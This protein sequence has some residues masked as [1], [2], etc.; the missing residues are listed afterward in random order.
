MRV[1]PQRTVP[2]PYW[3]CPINVQ[4]LDHECVTRLVENDLYDL[5]RP[6]QA[7]A[8]EPGSTFQVH[9]ELG[10]F[11]YGNLHTVVERRIIGLTRFLRQ[12]RMSIDACP[13]IGAADVPV[14][15]SSLSGDSHEGGRRPV[16]IDGESG[17]WVL[18]FADPRPHQ[19]LADVLGELSLAIGTDLRPPAVI[20]DPDHRWYFM[21]YLETGTGTRDGVDAF[22]FALGALTAVA[23]CL[24]MVDLH[25]ENLLV[26]DGKPVIVDPECILYNFASEASGDR[27]LSTGLLSHNPGLS[28]L[29][30]GDVKEQQ[31]VHIGLCEGAD[32]ILDYRKP[33]TSF[34]N[35]FR[36]AD[37]QL[38]DPAAHRS[39]L[40]GGFT[41]AYD[42]F[43]TRA[44]LVSD[45]LDHRVA[46]DFR[47][48]YLVRKTRLY[49]TAIHMLNL[50]VSCRYDDWRDGVFTRFRQ[51]GYFPGT[52]TE[53]IICA[54]LADMEARDVP[55]FWVE[56]SEPVIRHHSGAKQKLPGRW[57]ASEQTIRDIRNLSKQDMLDQ[58]GVLN[59]FLDAD[60]SVPANDGRFG[61][62]SE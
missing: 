33:A 42:W 1:R 16:V 7:A 36:G 52:V 19:L 21:P 30:G 58:L 22:M 56:A 38:A 15:F 34:H 4:G 51:A 17:R 60:L 18:K 13:E 2:D 40:I 14:E 59:A 47:I 28:A 27:L 35:R 29:R 48:R 39:S 26:F 12:V 3:A 8:N 43:R 6:T 57:N 32:G 55:Y 53:D 20:V 9:R 46:D 44:S 23:Y 41:A 49:I 25:L 10:G 5:L 31:I 54:E 11:S 37:G 24:R 50:P 45:I 62:A 61:P